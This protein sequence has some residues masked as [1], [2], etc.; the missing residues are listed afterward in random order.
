MSISDINHYNLRVPKENIDELVSFYTS[1][2]GLTVGHRPLKSIGYW[3]YA[4]EKSLLHLSQA[5]ADEQREYDK[6]NAF[7][8]IAFSCTDLNDFKER[9]AKNG[10]R[11]K[12]NEIFETEQVQLFLHDPIGNKIELNF[13][14]P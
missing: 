12:Q 14:S 9:L 10:I 1:V 5:L 13:S 11:Y 3:L 4:G 2:I 7:D 6:K 8:H